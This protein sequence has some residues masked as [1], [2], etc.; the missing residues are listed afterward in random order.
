MHIIF[1][2]IKES[3]SLALINKGTDYSEEIAKRYDIPETISNP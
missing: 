2:N 3:R 1:R